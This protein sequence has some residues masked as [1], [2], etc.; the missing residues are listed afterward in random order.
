MNGQLL[1]E[2][3]VTM[4]TSSK[5]GCDASKVILPD[6]VMNLLCAFE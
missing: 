5:E 3:N 1:E 2:V 4:F 6:F